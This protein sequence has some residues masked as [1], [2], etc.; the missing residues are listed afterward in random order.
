[1]IHAESGI[2]LIRTEN[3]NRD[4]KIDTVEIGSIHGE[5]GQILDECEWY[6]HGDGSVPVILKNTN[7]LVGEKIL[8]QI[9]VK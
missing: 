6:H 2:G 8:A 4:S 3:W 9:F 7:N 5:L 1:M